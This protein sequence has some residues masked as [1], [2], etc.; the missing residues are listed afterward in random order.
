MLTPALRLPRVSPSL[1]RNTTHDVMNLLKFGFSAAVLAFWSMTALPAASAEDALDFKEV[2]EL[3]QSQLS[4]LQ[5]KEL[6]TAAA[7]GLIQQ[8]QPRVRLLPED[9]EGAAEAAGQETLTTR[10]FDQGYGYV[11]I[12]RFTPNTG[13][14]FEASMQRLT[15]SNE[16]K[17]LVMD[18]RFAGGQDYASAARISDHFFATEQPLMDWGQGVKKSTEK[19]NALQMPLAVL[20]NQATAGPA[21]ALAGVARYGN[22]GLLVGS[23][24]AGQANMYREFKLATGQRL[25]V[26][27]QPVQVA[28]HKPMP[29]GGLEPDIKVVAEPEQEKAWLKDPYKLTGSALALSKAEPQSQPSDLQANASTNR[30]ARRRLNEADLVR[31]LR[32]GQLPDAEPSAGSSATNDA[33]FPP[34][35]QDPAL[36]RALDFLKG[37]SIV[38]GFR[39]I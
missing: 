11:R 29:I 19:T 30:P 24:T 4:D 10:V 18:L 32:D 14:A 17:G 35:I 8:L 33:G 31:M 13:T 16:L 12:D 2:Y 7:R 36:A 23:S 15:A 3:L 25:Q 39:S 5:A 27:T 28:D 37:L 22:L 6:D 1:T 9:T 21:E 38:R 34:Q 20:V 26:A